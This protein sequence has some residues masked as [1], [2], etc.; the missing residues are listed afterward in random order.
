[1]SVQGLL[2]GAC[3]RDVLGSARPRLHR[4]HRR[5]GHTPGEKSGSLTLAVRMQPLQHRSTESS[6]PQPACSL[7]LS[8]RP[9]P[10]CSLPLS[11]RP[12]PACSPPLSSRP[13][14]AC[15]RSGG[16]S[17]NRASKRE[18]PRRLGMT[19]GIGRRPDRAPHSPFGEP[20]ARNPVS[21]LRFA[22][23]PLVLGTADPEPLPRA[24]A[25]LEP[26][27]VGYA[28][29]EPVVVGCADPEPVVLGYADPERKGSRA[30]PRNVNPSTCHPRG[31]P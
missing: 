18:I 6:R 24:Y 17:I 29:L 22:W 27:V 31:A 4:E 5:A 8:S 14:R 16:I 28:D 19:I 9:E 13:Q 11:S 25:D 2:P 7:P 10:A 15:E 23:E 1:L 20:P 12:E 26:V 3:S 21:V 30:V